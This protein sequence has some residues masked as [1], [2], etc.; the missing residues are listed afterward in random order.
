MRRDSVRGMET[1][2]SAPDRISLRTERLLLRAFQLDDVERVHEYASDPVVTRFTDWGPNSIADT[3]AFVGES[4]QEAGEADRQSFTFA[5]VTEQD[6]TLVGT[7]AIWV[8]D[9]GHRRGELGAVFHRSVWNRGYATE[10]FRELV[11]FGLDELRLERIAA[12]CHPENTGSARALTKAGLR[13]EGRMRGH[14]RT[15]DGRRDSL[16]FAILSTDP[17]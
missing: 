2:P 13:A 6:D 1:A 11:R 5:A 8:E 3:R 17:R 16:L 4:V 12:T 9:A 7:V 15:R 10:A 14:L